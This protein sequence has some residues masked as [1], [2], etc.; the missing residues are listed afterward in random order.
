MEIRDA[1]QG[2][3]EAYM[4]L[5]EFNLL[6]EGEE[7]ALLYG[8][9]TAKHKQCSPELASQVADFMPIAFGRLKPPAPGLKFHDHYVRIDSQGRLRDYK[10]LDGE[11]AYREALS[12]GNELLNTGAAPVNVIGR[13]SPEFQM[14]KWALSNGSKVENLDLSPPILN[15]PDDM[16]P[17]LDKAPRFDERPWWMDSWKSLRKPWWKFW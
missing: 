2:A 10:P 13:I 4:A 6:V 5:V 17:P 8:A 3:I 16:C 12:M 9:V 15:G 1:I 14:I 7:R 11:P